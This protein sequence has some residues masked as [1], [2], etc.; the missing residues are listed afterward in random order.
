[1]YNIIS[2]YN[3]VYCWFY[4]V[5]KILILFLKF[6]LSI[7]V[8]IIN[9]WQWNKKSFE[10]ILIF[11]HECRKYLKK[12]KIGRQFA[13]WSVHIGFETLI[14]FEKSLMHAKYSGIF[15]FPRFEIPIIEQTMNLSNFPFYIP[16]KLDSCKS[17]REIS[18]FVKSV[19]FHFNE[20]LILNEINIFR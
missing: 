14:Q 1:M 16:Y 18:L 11:M 5:L 17:R 15:P 13:S 10:L 7:Y 19:L 8:Y 3:N 6:N 9:Y 4:E 2:Q 12:K 20:K